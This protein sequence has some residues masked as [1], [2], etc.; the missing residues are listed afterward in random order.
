MAAG[1][2]DRALARLTVLFAKAPQRAIE[3]DRGPLAVEHP[4]GRVVV[5]VLECVGPLG[6]VE[7]EGQ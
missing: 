5:S 4:L 1:V 2:G 7:I 6:L 3:R